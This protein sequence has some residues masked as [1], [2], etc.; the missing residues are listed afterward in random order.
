[1][2]GF[3]GGDW[4]SFS[5]SAEVASMMNVRPCGIVGDEEH[6]RSDQFFDRIR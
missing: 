1:M 6:G 5:V 2:S 4:Q 3:F